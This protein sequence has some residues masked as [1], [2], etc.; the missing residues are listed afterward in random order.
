[1]LTEYA[2]FLRYETNEATSAGA[3][4]SVQVMREPRII[5]LDCERKRKKKKEEKQHAPFPAFP[6]ALFYLAVPRPETRSSED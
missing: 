2:A 5:S 4:L 3:N 1:M 6:Y